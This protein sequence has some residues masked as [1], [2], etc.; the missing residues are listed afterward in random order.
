MQ[1]ANAVMAR[2]RKSLER[3]ELSKLLVRQLKLSNVNRFAPLFPL[4]ILIILQIF[5]AIGKSQSALLFCPMWR[6][7]SPTMGS[8]DPIDEIIDI[9][10]E[11]TVL[12]EE[13]DASENENEMQRLEL[14]CWSLRQQIQ[15]WYKRLQ[16]ASPG[17]L[18]TPTSN[19]TD[20]PLSRSAKIAFPHTFNFV[21]LEVAEAHMLCWAALLII[22]SSFHGVESQ[23]EFKLR[24]YASSP[25]SGDA[26]PDYQK[27]SE[28]FLREAE[29]YANQICRGVGYF[30]QPHMH[31]LGG[32]NLLFPVSMAAKFFY[33]NHFDDKYQ[34]CQEVFAVLNSIGL[35]LASVLQGTP[36]SRYKLGESH[37]NETE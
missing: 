12:V 2:H 36:W 33:G 20:T 30:L 34:W 15:T 13:I 1:G 35:G 4:T 28:V 7:M 22:S 21:A 3:D 24:A 19:L 5:H 27:R 26:H 29:F 23:R 18:Y 14:A 25:Y 32:H 6:A 10:M 8:D 37:A 9:L 17:R 16:A 31:I 11:C